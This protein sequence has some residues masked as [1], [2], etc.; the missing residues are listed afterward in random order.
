MTSIFLWIQ[1]IHWHSAT[2]LTSKRT[3]CVSVL[4]RNNGERQTMRAKIQRTSERVNGIPLFNIV[5]YGD[6]NRR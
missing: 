5:Y 1:S 3:I 4:R 2:E 6:S